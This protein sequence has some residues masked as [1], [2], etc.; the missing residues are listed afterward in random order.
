MVR[1]LRPVDRV[2]VVTFNSDVREAIP[3]QESARPFDLPDLRAAGS[4]RLYDALALALTWPSDSS[5][6]HLVLVLTDGVDGASK[7]EPWMMPLLWARS[8]SV[9]FVGLVK[10]AAQR[11]VAPPHL[12]LLRRAAAETGGAVVP[13]R[14]GVE[15][16]RRV[17]REFRGS[18]VLRYTPQGVGSDGWHDVT[19]S[20][21]GRPQYTVRGRKG[22]FAR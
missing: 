13:L 18:Y 17:L 3:M 21:V 14:G 6:R 12:D 1:M 16:F 11:D 15:L 19:V 2:R 9:L 22:Y 20:V 4:T 10:P 7:T 8:E 5:R